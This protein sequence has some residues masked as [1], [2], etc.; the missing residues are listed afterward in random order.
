M[1][2]S[3]ADMRWRRG[4]C[5]VSITVLDRGR[6]RTSKALPLERGR[7]LGQVGMLVLRVLGSSVTRII[8]E[9]NVLF[10]LAAGITVQSECPIGLIGDD[11]EA[12]CARAAE[13]FGMTAAQLEAL[14]TSMGPA[15][16]LKFLHAIGAKLGVEPGFVQGN[17]EG[18]FGVTPAE[19]VAKIAAAKQ[20]PAFRKRLAEKDMQATADWRMW[21]KIGYPQ[22]EVNT[23]PTHQGIVRRA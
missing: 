20:D 17:R 3:R 10:P 16:A 9:I 21:H 15:H 2:F 11:I 4:V 12:V 23:S 22:G 5:L 1:V 7:P 18:G 6:Y 13:K 14:K 19:A 8:D